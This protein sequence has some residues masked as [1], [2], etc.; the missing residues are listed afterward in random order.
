MR[1]LLILAAASLAVAASPAAQAAS[2][3]AARSG[4]TVSTATSKFGRILV[5]G[6]GRALYLF[7]M[8]RRGSSSCSGDCAANWPPVV[9]HGKPRARGDAR[10]SRLGTIA[11]DDGTRQ[12]T[13]RGHALYRYAGDTGRGQTNGQGLTAFGAAWYLMSASGRAIV[14]Y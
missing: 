10:A 2:P 14:G 11:R 5:D 3:A 13:Y 9:T 7:Q 8:D 4:A 6:H 12:V 1:R